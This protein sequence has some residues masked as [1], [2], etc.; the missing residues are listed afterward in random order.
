MTDSSPNHNFILILYGDF[1]CI[2]NLKNLPYQITG[3]LV[4]NDENTLKRM[5]Y[6]LLIN[7]ELVMKH[8]NT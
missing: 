1:K 7:L 6:Q 3:S 5:P 4:V 2:K 8:D